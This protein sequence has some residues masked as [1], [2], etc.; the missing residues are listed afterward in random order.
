LSGEKKREK[1]K[2]FPHQKKKQ[3]ERSLDEGMP[4]NVWVKNEVTPENKIKRGM[5]G[6]R[7]EDEKGELFAFGGARG[8]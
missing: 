8:A 1:A 3:F 2:K 6:G 5:K 4:S 7:K